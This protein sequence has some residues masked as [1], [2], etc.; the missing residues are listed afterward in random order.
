MSRL[1]DMTGKKFGGCLV[2]GREGTNKDRKATWECRCFCGKIFVAV[3]K[4]IRNRSTKSCGCLKTKVIRD[5]GLKRKT[6]GETKSRL[7][8]IWR[9]M[10][11]RCYI[12]G[13]TSYK[14]YG[15]KGIKVCKE[16]LGSYE[17][18]R[19]WAL[20]NGYK[21]H[22]TLDRIESDK[23]YTPDNCRWADWKTQERNRSNNVFVTFKDKKMT[24]SQVA[25]E[26]GESREM[27]G[28]RHKHGIDF[29]QPK[30]EIVKRGDL[31]EV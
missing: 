2:L 21:E 12:P 20:K 22:L 14:Y 24:L 27:V 23:D 9:G 4:D 31:K 29:E 3:G 15:A 30:R 13:D 18:F 25:E 1:I 11:K 17:S 10:K 26:I 6:H 19:D 16:W 7:Y 5:V 28:Y 8:N